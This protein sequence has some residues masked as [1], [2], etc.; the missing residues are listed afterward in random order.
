MILMVDV[1][2]PNNYINT[3]KFNLFYFIASGQLGR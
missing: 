3:F 2:N 1:I